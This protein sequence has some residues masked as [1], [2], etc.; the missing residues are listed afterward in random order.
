[1]LPLPDEDVLVHTED[2]TG[3]GSQP[4]KDKILIAGNHEHCFVRCPDWSRG[5][6]WEK[7]NHPPPRE[8]GNDWWFEV[9]WLSQAAGLP[10]DELQRERRREVGRLRLVPEDT[11]VLVTHPLKD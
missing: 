9:L 10:V 7:R 2:Y 5:S 1:M 3:S 11:D 6:V 8:R 4:N